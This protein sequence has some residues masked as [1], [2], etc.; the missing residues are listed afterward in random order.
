M[1]HADR[2]DQASSLEEMARNRGVE[3]VCA[4]IPSGDSNT[5]C[6]ECGDPIPEG[7]QT[8]IEGCKHCTLCAEETGVS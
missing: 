6:D 5:H 4:R 1:Q 2:L 7:R 3:D 8:A